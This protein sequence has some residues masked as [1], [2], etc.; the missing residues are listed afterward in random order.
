MRCGPGR[1][2]CVIGMISFLQTPEA[3]AVLLNKGMGTIAR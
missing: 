1:A 2:A 3:T